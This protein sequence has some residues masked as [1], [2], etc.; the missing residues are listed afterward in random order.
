MAARQ[1]EEQ[2]HEAQDQKGFGD[3]DAR[4]A[5]GTEKKH[6]MKRTG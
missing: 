2:A 1:I 5:E 6:G 3:G 4:Q